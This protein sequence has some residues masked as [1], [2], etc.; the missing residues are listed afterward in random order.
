[1]ANCIP[2]VA[3][4]SHAIS[5]PSYAT[6]TRHCPGRTVHQSV[7][8]CSSR[9]AARQ[10]LQK[11]SYEVLILVLEQLE[12]LDTK[13]VFTVRSVC[14]IFDALATPIAYRRIALNEKIVHSDSQRRFPSALEHISAY[15]NHVIIRSNLMPRGIRRVLSGITKLSSVTLHYVQDHNEQTSEFWSL[16]EIL[17]LGQLSRHRTKISIR[18]LP[19]GG[20]QQDLSQSLLNP[21]LTKHLVSLQLAKSVPPLTTKVDTLK[22]LLVQCPSL[23]TLEYEDLGRGTSF[24]FHAGECLPPVSNLV[25]KS[26]DWAHSADEV[27][28]HWNMSELRSLTLVSVP[29]YNFLSSV[30]PADLSHL[31]C[32]RVHDSLASS[33][34]RQEDATCGLYHLVKNHI[35]ALQILDLTCHTRL[36][37]LDAI[38]KHGASLREVHFRDHIGFRNDDVK[39][40]TLS[41]RD[42]A[43]LGR[44]LP[45]VHT[46]ELDMDAGL[47]SPPEFLQALSTFPLL[48]HLTL[49]VQTLVRPGETDDPTRD[50][51]YESAVQAFSFLLLQRDRTNPDVPWR[52]M[53][54]NVGGWRRV[55][56]R[57]LGSEWRTKNARGI[58]AERCFVMQRDNAGQYNVREE[59]CHDAREYVSAAQL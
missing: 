40:P 49:H 18:N 37:P 32:L 11:L 21:L 5:S 30:F 12:S 10:C 17:D 57:R 2:F 23:D 54:I 52:H 13:S 43:V 31:T 50:R 16:S 9:L 29:V 3:S 25:L 15:T 20:F 44:R 51:D 1:M 42:I 33:V 59:M 45:F 8:K 34:D 19:L 24:T 36:F 35:A 48:Q 14:R 22:R 58:F 55:M 6:T 47:C 53:T 39:C 41:P 27:E 46:L 26:Y 4:A 28:R 38:T 56:V 7:A